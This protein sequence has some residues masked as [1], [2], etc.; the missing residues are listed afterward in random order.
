MDVTIN[1]LFFLHPLSTALRIF[2][3]LV[4]SSL[5]VIIQYFLGSFVLK[6][7]IYTNPFDSSWMCSSF[8]FD[9]HSLFIFDY[10]QEFTFD[11]KETEKKSFVGKTKSKLKQQQKNNRISLCYLTAEEN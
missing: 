2:F 11:G 9:F 4:C 3:I 8:I 10:T 5:R 7:W 1:A 6:N